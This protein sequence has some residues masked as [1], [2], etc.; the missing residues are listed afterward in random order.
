MQLI[1]GLLELS[2][3][4]PKPGYSG[5]L[6]KMVKKGLSRPEAM[7]R[8][9]E[10]GRSEGSFY[11]AYKALKDD[12]VRLSFS[13]KK[14]STDFEGRRLEVW[15]KYGVV[16]QLLVS[17]KK[18]EAVEL[19]VELVRKARKAGFTEVVAGLASLLETH[20]GAIDFDKRKYK[21]YRTLRRTYS[22][23]LQDEMDV[24]ALQARLVLAVNK[25][26]DLK[27]LKPDIDELLMRKHGSYQ[28]VRFRFSVLSI[29]A[30]SIGKQEVFIS[31]L[32][33]TVG[34]LQSCEVEFPKTVFTNLYLRA[35]PKFVSNGDFAHAA[36][37]V[38]RGIRTIS[39]GAQGWHLFM[40]QKAC[41]GLISGKPAITRACLSKSEKTESSHG[42]PDVG[43]RWAA[44]RRILDEGGEMGFDRVW[45]AVF[46]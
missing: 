11:K 17:Q 39:E 15:Q 9:V 41:L 12:L 23:W 26:K 24:M 20:F 28:Y 35:I 45:G 29:W 34:Y 42:N 2:A 21:R 1:K 25:S 27:S 6:V 33:E 5:D 40:L 18:A 32:Q 31:A 4:S 43:R 8:W 14:Y 3:A 22:R 46:G 38:S 19:A 7:R 36:I 13:G 44:V 16:R 30:D 10:M 37:Y